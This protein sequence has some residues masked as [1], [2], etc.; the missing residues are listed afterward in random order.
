M[1][2][3]V[4]FLPSL[5]TPAPRA[6]CVV[7]DVLRATTTLAA[8]LE[9]G[10]AEVAVAA[11]LAAAHA[12]RAA[13]PDRLLAGEDG[14]LR[15][16]GFDLGNS[17]REA[18]AGDLAGRRAI[19]RT[20]NGTGALRAVAACEWVL[21]GCVRNAP[22]VARAAAALARQHDLD[23]TLVCSGTGGGRI[24]ALDD[25][26][27]AGLLAHLLLETAR[28]ASA[29]PPDLDD[30]ARAALALFDAAIGTT[31]SSAAARWADVFRQTASG[32]HLVALGLGAD[33]DCCAA[34]G[35]SATVPR[36]ARRGDALLVTPL[37]AVA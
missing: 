7:I 33:I 2:L 37:H 12:L 27:T 22:A 23:I 10:V 17:P 20:S 24:F 29:P 36:A 13:E 19:C 26:L 15:P 30:A 6:L 16:E 14:G 3:A 25:A 28:A 9:R 1:R 5:A 18:L 4:A 11:D 35:A 34:F 21:L 32:R 8:L 31:D